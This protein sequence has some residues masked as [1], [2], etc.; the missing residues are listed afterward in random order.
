[1]MSSDTLM[2][3][4][5]HVVREATLNANN[6]QWEWTTPDAL[7]YSP[8]TTA[9]LTVPTTTTTPSAGS[10]VHVHSPVLAAG[11]WDD[12]PVA[13]GDDTTTL[14]GAGLCQD[15][16]GGTGLRLHLAT[17]GRKTSD[18]DSVILQDIKYPDEVQHLLNGT[19]Q[20]NVDGVREP[21]DGDDVLTHADRNSD[22]TPIIGGPPIKWTQRL[23]SEFDGQF[24]RSDPDGDGDD[25]DVYVDHTDGILFYFELSV[26]VPGTIK[27]VCYPD[28]SYED[29]K[30]FDFVPGLA[31]SVDVDVVEDDDLMIDVTDVNSKKLAVTLTSVDT[32]PF[33]VAI[34]PM[35]YTEGT[36]TNGE[37]TCFV[38]D[39]DTDTDNHYVGIRRDGAPMRGGFTVYII[40]V[41]PPLFN[42]GNVI[43]TVIA[44]N[45]H[46]N[47]LVAAGEQRPE[48]QKG[49]LFRFTDDGGVAGNYSDYKTY[50]I[51]FESDHD[52]WYMRFV[53]FAFEHIVKWDHHDLLGNGMRGTIYDY[54]RIQSSENGTTA[55]E[56][57]DVN[58]DWFGNKSG[59]PVLPATMGYA[60]DAG[61]D[62]HSPIYVPHKFV[63]FRFVSDQHTNESGWNII[64]YSEPMDDWLAHEIEPLTDHNVD[65]ENHDALDWYRRDDATHTG[66][67]SCAESPHRIAFDVT[68]MR[69]DTPYPRATFVHVLV[70]GTYRLTLHESGNPL[71]VYI[72]RRGGDGVLTTAL[73]TTAE[74]GAASGAVVRGDVLGERLLND[75]VF[76]ADVGDIITVRTASGSSVDLTNPYYGPH[77]SLYLVRPHS[78]QFTVTTDTTGN[79]N[80][81]GIKDETTDSTDPFPDPP[82][83]EAAALSSITAP[84][85]ATTTTT[86]TTE[87]RSLAALSD[88]RR[89]VAWASAAYVLSPHPNPAADHLNGALCIEASD[90]ATNWSPVHDNTA[91]TTTAPLF[92]AV[93]DADANNGGTVAYRTTAGVSETESSANLYLLLPAGALVPPA[94]VSAGS[95]VVYVGPA[96]GDDG[97]DDDDAARRPPR[98]T[99]VLART[100]VAVTG[101]GNQT[102][103][104]LTVLKS[105]VV[106]PLSGTDGVPSQVSVAW[107]RPSVAPALA[108]AEGGRS[109]VISGARLRESAGDELNLANWDVGGDSGGN[110]YPRHVRFTY[111]GDMRAGEEVQRGRTHSWKLTMR[112]TVTAPFVAGDGGDDSNSNSNSNGTYTHPSCR[113][114]TTADSNQSFGLVAMSADGNRIAVGARKEDKKPTSGDEKDQGSVRIYKFEDSRWVALGDPIYG[115]ST[116]EYAGE[117]GVC[118]SSDGTVVAFGAPY[119]DDDGD[120]R[121]DDSGAVRV[122]ELAADNATWTIRGGSDRNLVGV[123]SEDRFGSN[124]GMS[125][126]GRV[127]A[128][129]TS[130]DTGAIVR[131][132]EWVADDSEWTERTAGGGIPLSDYGGPST[133]T[134]SLDA[135]GA[136]LAY[137]SSTQGTA[138]IYRWTGPNGGYVRRGYIPFTDNAGGGGGSAGA[139]ASAPHVNSVSLPTGSDSSSVLLV[140]GSAPTGV[141]TLRANDQS[142]LAGY[143]LAQHQ[144]VFSVTVPV[145]TNESTENPA[146][147]VELVVVLSSVP[148]TTPASTGAASTE[149]P[150]D[151]DGYDAHARAGIRMSVSGNPFPGQVGVRAFGATDTTLVG[152]LGSSGSSGSSGYE[153]V[154]LRF[155]ERTGEFEVL[156]GDRLAASYP[157]AATTAVNGL[158]ATLWLYTEAGGDPVVSQVGFRQNDVRPPVDHTGKLYVYSFGLDPERTG[159]PSGTLNFAPLD[160]ASLELVPAVDD[161]STVDVY[162]TGYNI[163]R[164]KDGTATVRFPS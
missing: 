66:D 131:V 105:D 103:V 102:Q 95:E 161:L 5:A 113:V 40:S 56:W 22:P 35:S 32:T 36:T 61:W 70:S 158:H 108:S 148:M 85:D 47:E 6:S 74:L 52:G 51:T 44:L 31:G 64:L 100:T 86:T 55:S 23:F 139:A 10:T 9:D 120:N 96:Y 8:N 24:K 119:A 163:L 26:P 106:S 123:R 151:A 81:L 109:G 138:V 110:A 147:K 20:Y 146:C 98:A 116:A 104:R 122:Y 91:T 67:G 90:D 34:V 21:T 63:R 136:V 125:G 15:S 126:D 71:H 60:T 87:P 128:V 72:N 53:S 58:V 49:S 140:V 13:D 78:Y 14:S 101:Q 155:D 45:E 82:E 37:T 38:Q 79:G 16:V 154:T 114:K 41:F 30:R 11:F 54:L 75:A 141:R 50:E 149:D 7:V 162:A 93:A 137:G 150:Y 130:H 156:L 19:G 73:G 39:D 160:S 159:V 124:I 121:E 76:D 164:V 69:V 25:V 77:V 83:Y 59:T 97:D 92:R 99:T 143:A 29:D 42:L 118:M 48:P 43:S 62:G 84:V 132:F 33:H 2:Q 94:S 115:N 80:V 133:S 3:R 27:L 142:S 57:L 68:K 111:T 1:M 135:T 144:G 153:R 134:I 127:V 117:R 28:P 112:S 88:L 65:N 145:P 89:L 157:A 129:S 18:D 152:S 17:V 46:T 107:L 4:R 12:I